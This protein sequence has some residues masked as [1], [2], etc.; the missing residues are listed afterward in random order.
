MDPINIIAG[1]NVIATFAANFSTANKNLK[2]TL[3][4]VRE[5]PKTFLQK[6]PLVVSS[7]TLLALIFGVF[8]IGTLEYSEELKTP[9][10]IG[11]IVY[12]IFSW[13]QILSFKKL[14][15]NYSQ[16]IVIKKNHQLVTTGIY[17]VIRHPQYLS[18]M[19][20]DIGGGLAVMSYIVLPLAIIEIPIL[21]MRA[22]LEDKLHNKYFGEKFTAYKKKSGFFFPFIG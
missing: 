19:L 6:F 10:L 20:L 1:L 3:T 13:L 22:T 18:Q 2:S 8:Q 12:L 4:E 16:E 14:D 11:L 17:S 9:R 15:D 5:K 21:I 7:F